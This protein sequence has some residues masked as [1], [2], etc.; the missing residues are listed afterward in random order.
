MHTV[1]IRLLGL[2]PLALLA[3]LVPAVVGDSPHSWAGDE[4]AAPATVEVVRAPFGKPLK[5]EGRLVPAKAHEI[6]LEPKRYGGDFVLAAAAE[7]DTIKEGALLLRFETEEYETQKRRA[8]MDL[9]LAR[10]KLEDKTEGHARQLRSWRIEDA[11]LRE[12]LR[13]AEDDLQYF[14]EVQRPQRIEEAE[15]GL[16]GRR[17][18]IADLKEELGQ[19][20]KMY[21]EDDL[22]EETEEIVL[23]RARRGLKRTLRSLEFSIAKHKRWLQESLGREQLD[24]EVKLEKAKL[25]FEGYEAGQR[26]RSRE[27]EISLEKARMDLAKQEESFAE[28]E[29]D[30]ELFEIRAPMDGGLLPGSWKQNGAAARAAAERLEVGEKLSKGAVLLTVLPAESMRVETTVAEKDL[31]RVRK[32]LAA[33]VVPVADPN[34]TLEAVVEDVDKQGEKG[35][36]GVRLRLETATDLM[37]GMQVNV[38]IVPVDAQAGLSVPASAIGKHDGQDVVYVVEGDAEPRPVAIEP[39]K[40]HAGRVS[41]LKGL[42][43]G[44]KILRDAPTAD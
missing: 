22:T 32:G 36:F 5:L 35:K 20:E 41:I 30:A 9:E 7:G 25:A 38:E 24:L 33:A 14:V 4:A 31:L 44:Q 12:K 42:E 10:L 17:D 28:L 18:R 34:T 39:G 43:A 27:A 19:L 15:H 37:P 16:E 21:K 3:C 13:R 23:H 1:G 8:A 2:L 6:K 29:A 26:T 11:G 40:V